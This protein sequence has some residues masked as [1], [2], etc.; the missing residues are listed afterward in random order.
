VWKRPV[1]VQTAID[2][3]VAIYRFDGKEHT[4]KQDG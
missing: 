4:V 2:G 1:C 3:K